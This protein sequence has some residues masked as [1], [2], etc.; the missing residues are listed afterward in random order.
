MNRPILL[1]GAAGCAASLLTIF[2]APRAA[3]AGWLAAFAF[4][5]ALPIGSIGLLMMMWVIPGAW[6]QE[7]A[8]LA[9][10]T[11]TLLALAAVAVLP[12]LLGAGAL[13]DWV[14]QPAHGYRAIYLSWPAFALR[15]IAFFLCLGALTLRLLGRPG[16][17]G[18]LSAGGLILYLLLATTIAVDW[19]MSLDPEFHSSGF[20]LYIVCIQMVSALAFMIAC[21]L[22]GRDAESRNGLLGALLLCGLLFWAYLAFMQYFIIWSNNLSPT[23]HWYQQRAE[24][25]WSLAEY[26]IGA[27]GLGPAFLLLF[28]PIRNGARWLVGLSLVVLA[29]RALEVAWIVLPT[30]HEHWAIAW[31]STLLAFAGLGALSLALPRA[32]PLARGAAS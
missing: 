7:L 28:T 27:S 29:G 4:W 11:S 17:A 3:L 24:G 16:R 12:I 32:W 2:A 1:F 15:T 18:A 31:I 14:H 26:A 10:R 6:R 13:Y 5:S 21:R 9:E 19:L 25:G 30:L 22:M 8:P 20:G 23:V